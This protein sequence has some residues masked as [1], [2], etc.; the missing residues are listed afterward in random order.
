MVIS[1]VFGSETE[2]RNGVVSPDGQ[3][4]QFLATL[5][6]LSRKYGLGMAG[7]NG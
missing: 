7:L 2:S 6:E 4:K 1:K 5:A 3:T